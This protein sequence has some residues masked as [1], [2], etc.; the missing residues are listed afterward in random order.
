MCWLSS[1][2]KERQKPKIELLFL[3]SEETKPEITQVGKLLYPTL[4]DYFQPYYFTRAEYWADI[5]DYIYFKFDMPKYLAARFDCDDFAVLL[6]GLV[7]SFF[8][9]NYFGV[10]FGST[11]AGYHAWNLFRTENGLMQ[12]EPQSGAYFPIGEKGYVPEYIL[13]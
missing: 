3:S 8:G 4:L 11:P 7:A 12:F 1:K 9:L 2:I 13:I 6:K 5:F 10:V